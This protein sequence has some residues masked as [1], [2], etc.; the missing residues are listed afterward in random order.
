MTFNAGDT[1]ESRHVG[2]GIRKRHQLVSTCKHDGNPNRSGLLLDYS[3][4]GIIP[5]VIFYPS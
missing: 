3:Q 2:L 1:N 4:T 5:A